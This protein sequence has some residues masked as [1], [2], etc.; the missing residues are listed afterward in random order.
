MIV[1]RRMK[2]KQAPAAEI[3]ITKIQPDQFGTWFTGEYD[4]LTFQAKVFDEGSDYGIN[5]GRISKLWVRCNGVTV[6]E[7]ERGWS[8]KPITEFKALCEDIICFLEEAP[9]TE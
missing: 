7:Y 9:T 8:I 5:E 6:L 1:V 2:T 4:N 3:E